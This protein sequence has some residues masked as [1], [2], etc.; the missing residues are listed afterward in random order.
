MPEARELVAD[1]LRCG[2]AG[3]PPDSTPLH[4]IEGWDSLTHVSLV[5]ALEDRL[6]AELTADEIRSI[7]TIADVAGVLREKGAPA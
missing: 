4:D 7:V 3:V 2:L 6:N 5:I 1:L